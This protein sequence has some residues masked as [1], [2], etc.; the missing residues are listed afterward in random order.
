MKNLQYHKK[1]VREHRLRNIQAIANK[2]I[3][4]IGRKVLDESNKRWDAIIEDLRRQNGKLQ[5]SIMRRMGYS[6][7]FTMAAIH[8]FYGPATDAIVRWVIDGGEI[9]KELYGKY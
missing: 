8:A 1:Q 4:A 5:A 3:D 7:D 2:R 9:P 6:G